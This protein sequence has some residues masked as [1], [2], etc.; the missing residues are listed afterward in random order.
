MHSTDHHRSL[1]Q[2]V[3]RYRRA[4]HSAINILTTRSETLEMQCFVATLLQMSLARSEV[5]LHAIAKGLRWT[6]K[7]TYRHHAASF[8][9]REPTFRCNPRAARRIQLLGLYWV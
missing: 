3:E 7:E 9:V 8:P 5:Q 2:S 1:A 6:C 4:R